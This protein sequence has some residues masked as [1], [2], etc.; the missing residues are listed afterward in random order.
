MLPELKDTSSNMKP[1][2][3]SDTPKTIVYADESMLPVDPRFIKYNGTCPKCSGTEFVGET[4]VMDTWA[5]TS[6][7]RAM[8]HD[9]EIPWNQIVLSGIVKNPQ[10]L[11]LS[12]LYTL[13]I[14]H[15]LDSRTLQHKTR[16]SQVVLSLFVYL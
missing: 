16:A 9:N 11:I 12:Y 8:I 15:H 5:F 4:D 13:N 7:V 10:G 6:I 14:S 2:A 1:E 3:K